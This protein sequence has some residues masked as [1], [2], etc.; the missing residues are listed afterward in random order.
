ME[1]FHKSI[2]GRMMGRADKKWYVPT[3]ATLYRHLKNGSTE[4]GQ[5]DL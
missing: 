5:D 3:L 1:A 4:K 2:G